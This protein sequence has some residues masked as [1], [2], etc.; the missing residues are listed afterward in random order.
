[1]LNILSRRRLQD[2]RKLSDCLI[3]TRQ[4]TVA[5]LVSES[6]RCSVEPLSDEKK[7]RLERNYSKLVNWLDSDHGLLAEMMTADC[8]LLRQKQFIESGTSSADRN[9]R[10]LDILRRGSESDF[11]KFIECLSKT[12]QKHVASLL[13]EDG[14]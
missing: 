8:I 11:N 10:L 2:L 5:R 13:M 14:L 4:A 12:G 3:A 6:Y 7:S 1:L 9:S